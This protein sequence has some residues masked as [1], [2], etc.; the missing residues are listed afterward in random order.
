VPAPVVVVEVLGREQPH[1]AV[2]RRTQVRIDVRAFLTPNAPVDGPLMSQSGVVLGVVGPVVFSYVDPTAATSADFQLYVD[3]LET[4]LRRPE[5]SKLAWINVFSR[6]NE[7]RAEDRKAIDL[8]RE[9]HKARIE[10]RTEI[11]WIVSESALF[12]TIL[13]TAFMLTRSPFPS[14]VA[15][16]LDEAWAET[17]RRMPGLSAEGLSTCK[18]WMGRVESNA[19]PARI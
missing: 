1:N 9:R 19:P 3:R 17:N 12:R 7:M 14:K 13:R 18:R 2:R 11:L 10:A 5:T 8:C 6:A 15:A 16:T 4:F